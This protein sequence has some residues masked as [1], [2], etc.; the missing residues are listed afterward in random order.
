MF[1]YLSSS[2]RAISLSE[3]FITAAT[4]GKAIKNRQ[5]SERIITKVSLEKTPRSKDKRKHAV[6]G[7]GN[8][9]SSL[10]ANEP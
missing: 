5:A 8:R 1:L 7:S 6:K 10:N 4:V 9:K 2:D 3:L